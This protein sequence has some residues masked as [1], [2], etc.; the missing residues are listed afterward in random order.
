MTRLS[1]WVNR[2]IIFLHQATSNTARLLR[3]QTETTK[4]LFTH[5]SKQQ[6]LQSYIQGCVE[7]SNCNSKT[8]KLH[9][10]QLQ[11]L[12][13]KNKKEEIQKDLLNTQ[14]PYKA[15]LFP[16]AIWPFSLPEKDCQQLTYT[17]PSPA[18]SVINTYQA[19]H[20]PYYF[21]ST[22]PTS[23]YNFYPFYLIVLIQI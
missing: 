21:Y 13:T 20:Y 15:I 9:F 14:H 18:I 6:H 23:V 11:N 5:H 17:H 8:V 10:W 7:D 4:D 16:C 19:Y 3:I 12:I 1:T 2:D 22:R